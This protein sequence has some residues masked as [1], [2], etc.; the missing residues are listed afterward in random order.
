MIEYMLKKNGG[1]LSESATFGSGQEIAVVSI[2]NRRNN[3]LQIH[4]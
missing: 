3:L 1:N 4:F 2:E